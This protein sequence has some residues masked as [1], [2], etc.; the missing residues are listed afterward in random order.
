MILCAYK[1]AVVRQLHYLNQMCG[2]VLTHTL[3]AS[4]LKT[5][6]IIVIKL[7]TVA[8]TLPDVSRAIGS[9]YLRALTQMAVISP[10]T[11][12]AAHI[13]YALLL[14]HEVNYI[15]GRIGSHFG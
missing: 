6:A 12:R 11:H 2:R 9:L 14:L 15:V 10:Q 3:H 7:K 4:L 13:V 1:P 5:C 8:V